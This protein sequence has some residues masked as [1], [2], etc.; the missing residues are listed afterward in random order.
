MRVFSIRFRNFANTGCRNSRAATT[1]KSLQD[2]KVFQKSA[3]SQ[4]SMIFVCGVAIFGLIILIHELGHFLVGRAFG[5]KFLSFSIGMGPRIRIGRWLGTPFYLSILP[6]GG[7]VRPL[8]VVDD[9]SDDRP[10]NGLLQRAHR[11]LMPLSDEEMVAVERIDSASYENTLNK[12]F[13]PQAC[14]ILGGCAFNLA[15]VFLVYFVVFAC[16]SKKLYENSM[17]VGDVQAQSFAAHAGM[18]TGDK[19]VSVNGRIAYRWEPILAHMQQHDGRH[20]VFHVLR[21]TGDALEAKAIRIPQFRH[22]YRSDAPVMVFKEI[23]FSP[24][25]RIEQS[26]LIEAAKNSIYLI[27]ASSEALWHT[28]IGG[29]DPK[30]HTRSAIYERESGIFGIVEGMFEIGLLASQSVQSFV[31]HFGS[32]SLAVIFLN[33]LP[34]PILDGGQFLLLVT[35][36]LSGRPV[37]AN[38]RIAIQQVGTAALL[39]LTVALF[40]L[41]IVKAWL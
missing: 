28:L 36:K 7:Y 31:V 5:I 11:F 17:A 33:L 24:P 25:Y 14:M 23:G 1:R 27:G 8:A 39:V 15:S 20:V 2:I 26:G 19:I 3:D 18:Q 29:D 30:K 41:D 21:R 16:Q 37:T 13:V 12:G 35:E 32:A 6:I 10:T 38:I 34:L 4:C 22:Y 9:E 40:G